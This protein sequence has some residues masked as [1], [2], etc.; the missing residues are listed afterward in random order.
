VYT[1]DRES[2]YGI[3]AYAAAQ[4]IGIM[5]WISDRGP[6]RVILLR[7][8]TITVAIARFSLSSFY[9]WTRTPDLTRKTQGATYAEGGLV[10]FTDRRR[11]R[12]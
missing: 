10:C 3:G 2:P 5:R 8:L 7:Y 11:L 4:P 12:K 1:L 9:R 6:Y